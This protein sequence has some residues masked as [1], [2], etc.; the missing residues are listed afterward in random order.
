MSKLRCNGNAGLTYNA[1]WIIYRMAVRWAHTRNLPSHPIVVYHSYTWKKVNTL[2]NP[3]TPKVPAM[4]G[5]G[6]A[7]VL[8]HLRRLWLLIFLFG[9]EDRLLQIK[10]EFYNSID[11]NLGFGGIGLQVPDFQ[12]ASV[13]YFYQYFDNFLNKSYFL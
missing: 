2:G 10:A 8:P 13:A 4:G 6:S 5:G 11:V 3:S 7:W 1:C 12:L 9:W